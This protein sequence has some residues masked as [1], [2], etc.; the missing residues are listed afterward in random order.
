MALLVWLRF[1]GAWNNMYDAL[2]RL[3]CF[4]ARS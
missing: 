3:L 1:I 2:Q 4:E